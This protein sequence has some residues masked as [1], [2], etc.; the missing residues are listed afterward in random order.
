MS[1]PIGALGDQPVQLAFSARQMGCDRAEQRPVLGFNVLSC[2]SPP[3]GAPSPRGCDAA[4]LA[5]T[6]SR[7]TGTACSRDERT[8]RQA[9]TSSGCWPTDRASAA[10]YLSKQRVAGSLV[11]GLLR[12]RRVRMQKRVLRPARLSRRLESIDS[13]AP[14]QGGRRRL[15]P[16]RPVARSHDPWSRTNGG[17]STRN[18]P[19]RFETCGCSRRTRSRASPRAR[20]AQR[21]A[22]PRRVPI[23][24]PLGDLTSRPVA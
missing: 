19:L 5:R 11:A 3:R 13:A 23:R 8:P 22:P 14:R 24:E 16:A 15:Q 12:H 2:R 7:T 1:R 18:V 10:S 17:Y 6:S 4:V 21:P 9:S 20:H